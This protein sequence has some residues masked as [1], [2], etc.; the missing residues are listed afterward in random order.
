MYEHIDLNNTPSLKQLVYANLLRQIVS[1]KLPPNTR[2]LETDI[3]KAMNVSRV[4]IR[5]ALN[6][7]ERDGFTK[8]IP[9]KGSIVADIT[10]QSISEIWE[11]RSILEPYAARESCRSIP[12]DV[13]LSL[14]EQLKELAQ[15]PEDFD[16]YIETDC[17]VHGVL[18][19]FHKNK[20][21]ADILAKLTSHSIR[22][23]WGTGHQ[24]KNSEEYLLSIQDHMAII[25]ALLECDPD[26]VYHAVFD[27]IKKSESRLLDEIGACQE[28]T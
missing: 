20:Y 25:E 9:H 7:L 16:K 15:N 26:T 22:T 2:L 13:L 21:L 17:E 28:S 18:Y 12:K 19:R 8:I 24:D 27:H 5:E 3:A 14:S 23:Q 4:P 1:G 6:M 10:P 11:L